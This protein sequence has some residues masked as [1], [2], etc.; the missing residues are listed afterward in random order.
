MTASSF[1]WQ[2]PPDR[3][4]LP[5]D[6]VHV[7]QV[8]L[9]LEEASLGSLRGLLSPE[10]QVRADQFRFPIHRGRFIAS[11]AQLR[12]LLGRYLEIEPAKLQFN[13]NAYGKPHLSTDSSENDLR[14]NVAHSEGLALF[15][16]ARQREVGV[17]LEWIR[18]KRADKQIAERFFSP[19]EAAALHALPKELQLEGFY[20]CWTRK[21][22][23][24][25]ALG[26]GLAFPLDQF[27]VSLAPGEPAALLS[28]R[29][30]PETVLLWTLQ[31][32]APILGY[33][34][35]LA[36]EGRGW[37]LQCWQWQSQSG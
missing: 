35:A 2:S 26:K 25:K 37:Q 33:A 27:E 15:A 20:N 3:L 24:I 4:T 16:V 30:E 17:D 5:A 28:A 32:L 7:W 12:M 34:A 14:F 29:E 1:A 9:D 11:R 10:E 22:A 21:E 23:F 31:D 36:V 13:Y 19:G 6:E 18:P 8:G